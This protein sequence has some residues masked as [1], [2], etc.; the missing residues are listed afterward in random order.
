LPATNQDIKDF[1]ALSGTNPNITSAQLTKLSDWAVAVMQPVDANG[2]PRAANA[3]DLVDYLY[4][5]LRAKIE[6]WLRDK[7][8]VTF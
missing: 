4:R 1:F 2:D 8:Q 6:H 7:A 3:D 5:D